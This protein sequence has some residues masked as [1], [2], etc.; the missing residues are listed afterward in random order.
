[1]SPPE[2][3]RRVSASA[4][5][6]WCGARRAR[7]ANG[8][9]CDGDRYFT[10]AAGQARGQCN[11]RGRGSVSHV[12]GVGQ[13]V[14]LPRECCWQ[15]GQLRVGGAHQWPQGCENGAACVP[16]PL[17]PL[18]SAAVLELMAARLVCLVLL[19]G[20]A[21]TGATAHYSVGKNKL[22]YTTAYGDLTGTVS[23]T[24]HTSSAMLHLDSQD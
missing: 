5:R 1:M 23:H 11:M 16:R 22:S 9:R 17:L 19:T 4:A 8:R 2:G 3:V 21:A 12:S 7:V 6:W 10:G 15:G 13:G 24:G 18:S 14:R 20:D